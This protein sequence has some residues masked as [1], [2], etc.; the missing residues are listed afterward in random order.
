M[1]YFRTMVTTCCQLYPVY[2]FDGMT[3]C[4][5][6]SCACVQDDGP[7]QD[8][9]LNLFIV[10]HVFDRLNGHSM[11]WTKYSLEWDLDTQEIGFIEGITN[12]IEAF[13]RV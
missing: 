5:H 7:L 9:H 10:P 2:S 6:T 13:R 3:L 12:R 1:D 4:S 8:S 11:Y